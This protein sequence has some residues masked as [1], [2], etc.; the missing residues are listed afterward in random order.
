MKLRHIEVFHAVMTYGSVNAA[1]RYLNT[2]Q[3]AL[4]VALKQMEDS[5]GYPLFDRQ[6][7]RLLPTDSAKMLHEQSRKVI[8][9]VDIFSRLADN[10]ARK[11]AEDVSIGCV[12]A[13]S[14]SIM[15]AALA[16]FRQ[17]YPNAKISL[18]TTHKRDVNQLLTRKDINIGFMF[19]RSDA[20]DNY[21]NLGSATLYKA[22]KKG[23]EKSDKP[24]IDIQ[25]AGPVG[26]IV[27]K[28]FQETRQRQDWSTSVESLFNALSMASKGHGYAIVDAFT[29]A[30]SVDSNLVFTPLKEVDQVQ[31]GVIM[32]DEER[33]S[34]TLQT[35]VR[36]V[37]E[38]VAHFQFPEKK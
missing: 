12:P 34:R 10:I 21:D 18:K 38:E 29:A 15:P 3:P 7:G 24:Y 19:Y 16:R 20:A 32:R 26:E 14:F 1:A 9:E 23:E 27:M 4:S 28:H 11:T 30:S 5:L 2:S 13:L 31:V 22:V 36:C 33:A 35:L 6:R 8:E 25:D 17:F 37:R